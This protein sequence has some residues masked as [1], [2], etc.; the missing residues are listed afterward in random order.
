MQVHPEIGLRSRPIELIAFTNATVHVNPQETIL[1]ASILVNRGKIISVGKDIRIPS[2]ART[3][4]C[5]GNHIYPGFID[6]MIPVE[7]D[8]TLRTSPTKHWNKRIHP[9]YNP[10]LSKLSSK[11]ID[12]KKLRSIG[13][14]SGVLVPKSGIFR[15]HGTAIEL[16]GQS[17]S[18]YL[19]GNEMQHIAM[20]HGGWDDDD[21]PNSLL[22]SIALIRQTFYDSRWYDNAWSIFNSYPKN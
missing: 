8:T 6:M 15:G 10:S 11:S 13:F 19:D 12:Y 5:S 18:F 9:E 7:V 1:N 4:D 16:G 20:E 21:Y 17:D 22:G 3:I 14:T 2:H